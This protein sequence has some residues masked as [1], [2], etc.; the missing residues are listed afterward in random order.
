MLR[1]TK[2]SVVTLALDAGYTNPSHFAGKPA[3]PRATTAVSVTPLR[4]SGPIVAGRSTRNKSSVDISPAVDVAYRNDSLTL[5]Y[6]G[7]DES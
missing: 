7:N 1:E 5:R 3:F 2:K 4:G 6:T